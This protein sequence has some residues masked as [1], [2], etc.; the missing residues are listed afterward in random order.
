MTKIQRLKDK[1]VVFLRCLHYK[2][3]RY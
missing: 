1:K 2:A 3:L